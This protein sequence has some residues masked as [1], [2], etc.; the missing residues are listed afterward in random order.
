MDEQTAKIILI[1]KPGSGKGS[2]CAELKTMF[3][4]V[5]ISAGD[6]LRAEM[7]SGNLLSESEKEKI[8]NGELVSDETI[9][10]IL[11]PEIEKYK[12]TGIIFDG[13][14]RNL[15]QAEMLDNV[16]Q[17]LDVS[18]TNVIEIQVDD[19]ILEQR[20]CGRRIHPSSGRLYHI[21]FN[22]PNIEGLDDIT[23]EPLV[24]RID[25]TP[26]V[27]EARLREYYKETHPLL[28]YYKKQG[29][30]TTI[31]GSQDQKQ[32]L[33]N[34]IKAFLHISKTDVGQ[35]PINENTDEEYNY[36]IL[37]E[38]WAEKNNVT[39][40]NSNKDEFLALEDD[41]IMNLSKEDVP[42]ASIEES[43]QVGSMFRLRL[44]GFALVILGNIGLF[45]CGYEAVNISVD[46]SKEKMKDRNT[47]LMLVG[48]IFIVIAL[49]CQWPRESGKASRARIL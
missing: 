34:V 41:Y 47:P 19:S 11:M 45:L 24:Q 8:G 16:F 7:K 35:N 25:D 48:W 32:T 20:I 3:N 33:E 39:L 1:G 13:F 14:P 38:D 43:S 31:D 4:L 46:S 12:G 18:L 2:V 36:N 6:L 26:D 30:L 17:E 22:P 42:R 10:K 5:H 49:Y 44:L 28:D 21:D 27:L 29:I 9:I 15:A 37:S 23:G 40:E